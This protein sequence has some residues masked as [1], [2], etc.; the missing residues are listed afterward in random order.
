MK[1][2]KKISEYCSISVK[3][4]ISNKKVLYKVPDADFQLTVHVCRGDFSKR[5]K[6]S[7]IRK[8]VW[9]V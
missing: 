9:L 6:H 2:L 7:K 4:S 3:V 5:E 8:K 1:E